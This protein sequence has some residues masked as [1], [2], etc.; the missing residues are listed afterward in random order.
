MMALQR[1]MAEFLKNEGVVATLRDSGKP[2]GL[3]VTTGG[4][5]TGDRGS[6]TPTAAS[7]FVA[8]EDYALLYR[9]VTEHK[10]TPKVELEVKNTFTTGPVTVNNTVGEV[11][12]TE[13]PDEFVVVGAHLDSWDLATGTTDNGTGSCVVLETARAVAALAKAGHG[14][15]RTVRFV[16]FTGEEQGLHGSQQYVAR[17]KDEM[18]KTSLALVHDTGTG[19]VNG[20]GLLGREAV[21]KVLAGELESLKSVGFSGLSPRGMAGGTDHASFNRVGVP[22]FAAEQDTDEYRFTHHTQSDTFD[23]AKEPN[24]I[25][26]AQV[27]A[28]TAVRVANLP[29]LLPRTPPVGGGPGGFGGRRG[30][31]E[32]RPADDKKGDEKKPEEKKGEKK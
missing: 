1:E 2:H 17:H 26:G 10:E 28:V 30:G 19:K 29:E 22:G 23:K 31:T 7:L 3:L 15:K 21:G 32:D 6:Q 8:H 14:P 16:L 27:M 18:A 11:R 5:Q 12:G 20:F 24:L 25:Q 9:L 4:W 13:K